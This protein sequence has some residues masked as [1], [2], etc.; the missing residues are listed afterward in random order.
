MHQLTEAA[1]KQSVDDPAQCKILNQIGSK[2]KAVLTLGTRSQKPSRKELI[3]GLMAVVM[4]CRATRLTYSRLFSSVT[5][6]QCTSTVSLA[7]VTDN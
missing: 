3:C 1:R 5:L 7:A 2:V 6:Q 4:R